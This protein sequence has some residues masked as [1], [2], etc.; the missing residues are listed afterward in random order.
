MSG[1]KPRLK[2]FV[3]SNETGSLG[4]ERLRQTLASDGRVD[5]ELHPL[6]DVGPA[7]RLEE[8][9]DGDPYPQPVQ[10]ARR[11]FLWR[12]TDVTEVTVPAGGE[13]RCVAVGMQFPDGQCALWWS[14]PDGGEGR[15]RT[16]IAIW[17]S[18]SDLEA[19]HLHPKSQT[20]LVWI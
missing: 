12:E 16:S 7:K 10:E 1:D 14:P 20:R 19:V 18:V 15:P 8:S 5:Y 2:V 13:A 9:E 6:Y 3:L 11:F 4:V 17:P